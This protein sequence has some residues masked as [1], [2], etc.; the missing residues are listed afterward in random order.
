MYRFKKLKGEGLGQGWYIFIFGNFLKFPLGIVL[1]ALPIIYFE[2]ALDHFDSSLV[3]FI[4]S[5]ISMTCF[6]QDLPDG[7]NYGLFCPPMNGR[8]GKFLDEER[9]LRDYPLSTPI[10][11]LE[12]CLQ[13]IM[14]R[15]QIFYM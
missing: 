11:F 8:A 15:F 2:S 9:P 10:G 5:Y 12:V 7:I 13:R 4:Q 6:N 3:V 1:A 14:Q